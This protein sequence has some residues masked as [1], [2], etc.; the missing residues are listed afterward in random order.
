MKCSD[1]DTSIYL[2]FTTCSLDDNHISLHHQKNKTFLSLVMIQK[3]VI[4]SHLHIRKTLQASVCRHSWRLVPKHYRQTTPTNPTKMLFFL[5][6]K[7]M[8]IQIILLNPFIVHANP[9]PIQW[10]PWY[11]PNKWEKAQNCFNRVIHT[12]AQKPQPV[13]HVTYALPPSGVIGGKLTL[14]KSSS[15]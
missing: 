15:V 3:Q 7:A 1:I 4:C 13:N 2:T 12:V 10:Y 14:R 9:I 11:I 8:K 5:P 6:A